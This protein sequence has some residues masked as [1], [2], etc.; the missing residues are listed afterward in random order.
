MKNIVTMI[1]STI[2]GTL[3]LM[4]VMTMYGRSARSMELQRTLPSVVEETLEN[5]TISQKYSICDTNEFMADLVANL[6]VCMDA[7][8]DIKVDIL[9]CETE[10]GIL[11]VRVT[12]FYQHV[13]GKTG[14]VVCERNVILNRL[15]S[16]KSRQYKVI[17]Y[18]STECYKSYT[19]QEGQIITAPVNPMQ[20][21]KVFVGWVDGNGYVA[22]FMQP[23][24]Q[25]ISYYASW[26]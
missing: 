11:S 8:S 18:N 26:R 9:Q 3:V 2:L 22:D 14:S 7:Q 1:V 19:L 23:V 25:D 17:F 13:N 12:A 4:V 24:M 21:D 16:E 6:A 10:K 5:M 15:E 20:K